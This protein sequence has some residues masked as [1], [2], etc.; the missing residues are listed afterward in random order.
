MKDN[1]SATQSALK[2]VDLG[3]FKLKEETASDITL[4][5]GCLF[6][7]FKATQTAPSNSPSTRK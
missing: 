3:M 7:R 2:N 1:N 4:K 6:S 5:Q